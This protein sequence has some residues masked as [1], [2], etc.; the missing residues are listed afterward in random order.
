M[1]SAHT[2][3]NPNF[4]LFGGD[5]QVTQMN[6]T[7][8]QLNSVPMPTANRLIIQNKMPTVQQVIQEVK[9]SA[10]QLPEV[11]PMPINNFPSSMPAIINP[12]G[13]SGAPFPQIATHLRPQ[14]PIHPN[15]DPNSQSFDVKLSYKGQVMH[16]NQPV[17]P[18]LSSLENSVKHIET[19]SEPEL[20]NCKQ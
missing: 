10:T 6:P 15:N 4:V 5:N 17:L 18:D 8:Q 11:M 3:V 2:S 9:N 16:N 7:S 19:L 12:L 14:V 1:A 20:T 13:Q